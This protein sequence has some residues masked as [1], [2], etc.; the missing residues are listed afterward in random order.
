MQEGFVRLKVTG[1]VFC[2]TAESWI[3]NQWLHN[4]RGRTSKFG[5][6][7][8]FYTNGKFGKVETGK[9]LVSSW[10]PATDATFDTDVIVIYEE[11]VGCVWVIDED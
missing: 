10:N 7:A 4:N 3:G 2:F 8:M 5:S 6:E 9:K 1:G 11:I